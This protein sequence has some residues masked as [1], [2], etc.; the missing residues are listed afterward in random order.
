MRVLFVCVGN[1]CRSPMAEGW[2]NHLGLTAASCGTSGATSVA[3]HSVTVMA[4]KG[5]DISEHRPRLTSEFDAADWDLVIS[6]GCGVV[7]SDP[8]IDEDWE[9]PDPYQDSIE[10]YRA[11]RDIL[12]MKVR[13]LVEKA[14]VVE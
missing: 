4:E 13:E 10:K 14:E 2:A 5:I 12:E 9:I 7:C 1:S 6:M 8:Q 11:T 3:P